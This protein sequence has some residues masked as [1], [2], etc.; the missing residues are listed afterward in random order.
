MWKKPDDGP[1]VEL[2]KP[3]VPPMLMPMGIG[4]KPPVPTMLMVC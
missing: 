4:P 1:V 2:P 3:G